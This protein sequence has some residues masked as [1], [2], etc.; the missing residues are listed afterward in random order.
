MNQLDKRSDAMSLVPN[1]S[2]VPLA[3][4]GTHAIADTASGAGLS[5]SHQ[6]LILT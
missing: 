4:N 1:S 3:I 5:A 6:K 2:K